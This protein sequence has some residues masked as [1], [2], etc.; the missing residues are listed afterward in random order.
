MLCQ[1]Y[2]SWNSALDNSPL[3]WHIVRNLFPPREVSRTSRGW[4]QAAVAAQGCRD[5][6]PK[7]S[8]PSQ[9]VPARGLRV[10]GSWRRCPTR[11]HTLSD[12]AGP[13]AV[14]RRWSAETNAPEPRKVPPPGVVWSKPQ[15]TACGTP[16]RRRTCGLQDIRTASDHMPFRL[17]FARGSG[18]WVRRTPGVPRALDPSMARPAQTSGACAARTRAAV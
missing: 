18:P 11:S 1:G 9:T 15:N 5:V 2:N 13:R 6:H 8:G 14:V 10:T 3:S 4:G 12:A 17:I 7:R 16:E